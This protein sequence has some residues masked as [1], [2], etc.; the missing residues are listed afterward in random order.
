MCHVLGLQDWDTYKERVLQFLELTLM[1]QFVLNDLSRTSDGSV[2]L[3][4]ELDDH[5]ADAEEQ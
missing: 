5:L 3:I 1:R 4:N 2:K